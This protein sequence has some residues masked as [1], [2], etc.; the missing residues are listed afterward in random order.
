VPAI[1]TDNDSGALDDRAAGLRVPSDAG[2]APVCKEQ[3]V[4]DEAFADLGA[5]LGRGVDE[6]L[7]LDGPPRTV[8]QPRVGRAWLA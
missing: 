7:V 8:R 6:Q 5:G 1:R 3:F 2:D 4:D